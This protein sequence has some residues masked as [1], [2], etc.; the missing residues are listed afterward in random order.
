MEPAYR[1]LAH[2]MFI[3]NSGYEQDC[4]GPDKFLMSGFYCIQ[5]SKPRKYV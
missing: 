4:H 2:Y 1:E 5:K 3:K